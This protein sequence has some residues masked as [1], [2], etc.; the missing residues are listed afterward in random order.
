MQQELL[1]SLVTKTPDDRTTS[2]WQTQK[3][4]Q[5]AETLVV[6]GRLIAK[7]ALSAHAL[8]GTEEPQDE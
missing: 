2:V 3:T 5:R 6:L 8:A 4:E 1:L 7:A